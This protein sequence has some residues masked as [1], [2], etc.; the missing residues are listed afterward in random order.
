VVVLQDV[1]RRD[2]RPAVPDVDLGLR[3]KPFADLVEGALLDEDPALEVGQLV[4]E[5]PGSADDAE[6]AE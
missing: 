5:H 4:G 1:E 6:D 2:P 3:R